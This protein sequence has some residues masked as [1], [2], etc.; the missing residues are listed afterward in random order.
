MDPAG[1]SEGAGTG[2]LLDPSSNLQSRP[3]S[4]MKRAT[5]VVLLCALIAFGAGYLTGA[6]GPF[7][8]P[9]L[10]AAPEAS[11][12]EAAPLESQALVYE[13]RTYTAPEGKL[14]ALHQRFRDHT[15]RIFERHGMTNIGYWVPQD[16]ERSENTLVYILAHPTREAARESWAAFSADPEW[17]QV[18]RDSQVDGRI[19]ERVESVFLDP[20]DYSPLR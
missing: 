6:A 18:S 14:G 2:I 9:Q 16:E 11:A 4:G 12:R 7:E 8:V 15:M 13:L 20:T 1:L 10:D 17:Q 5:P 19:V 3:E